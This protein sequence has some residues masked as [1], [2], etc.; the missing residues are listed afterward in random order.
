MNIVPAE[1]RSGAS[2]AA[3]SR[4]GLATRLWRRRRLF[5][6]VF[7]TVFGLSVAAL[8]VLPVRFAATGSVIVAEPE[9]GNANSSAAWAQ[10]SG[11]PADLESQ[12]L[13]VRSPR[14]LRLAMAEPG[15]VEAAQRECRASASG[16]A[17]FMGSASACDALAANSGALVDY[18]ESRVSVGNVGRSRVLTVTY[19]SPLP[20]VAQTIAN[21]VIT[22][23]MDDQRV[24]LAKSRE[25][26][27]SYIL[28]EIQQLDTTLRAEEARI[29]DFRR[30]RGLV[31]GST[32]PI[33]SE[34]LTS[35]SQQLA[36]AEAARADAR[37]RLREI[38]ADQERGSADS[39][40]VL[41]SRA[42]GDLKQQ[43]SVLSNQ[44]ANL[45]TTLGPNY[46]AMQSLRRERSQLQVRLRSEVASVAASSRQ[47]YDAAD[48]LVASL[49]AQLDSAKAE[50][51]SV[52]DAEATLADMRRGV[53][54]KRT[55]YADLFRRASELE[56]ERRIL[57]GST[58]IVS[59][60]ELPTRPFFP[61]RLPFL[62]AG[63]TLAT[64]LAGA[65]ALLR[66]RTDGTVRAAAAI[67]YATGTITV[68]HLPR[69]GSLRSAS[70][71]EL[72][73]G[74]RALVLNAALA[75]AAVDPK[76]QAALRALYA[77]LA[78]RPRQEALR[79]VLVTSASP[80][81]GKTF[82][83]IAL[84]CRI[85][86]SGKRVLV[87]EGDMCAPT[88]AD[89]LGLPAGPGLAEVLRGELAPGA[90]V[91]R[92]LVPNL[93]ALPAGPAVENSTELL[94]GP[95]TAK[96]FDLAKNYDLVLV[97]SPPFG[98]LLDAAVL[99]TGVDGVLVCA[100]W[101]RSQVD[102]TAATI[103]GIQAAGGLVVGAVLTMVRPQDGVL[104]G[105]RQV[106]AV[107]YQGPA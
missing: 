69:L 71:S 93:D 90:A 107:A 85:A 30:D 75:Q 23:F 40:A 17:R 7:V 22:A 88:F 103:T 53:E 95:H 77:Q 27:A 20:D 52:T 12:L 54:L 104:Y 44:I 65:A 4:T 6:G 80:D 49:K 70:R 61:R 45:E 31:R 68:A 14:I 58:R 5:L 72:V 9:P 50:V 92:T 55:Q 76:M 62:A 46:P 99:A 36:V 97:D 13:Q 98:L 105:E 21:A 47:T 100:R 89:A 24:N 48:T 42:I 3:A 102:A 74:R 82:T 28:Q 8:F 2:A 81:E 33:A 11:D 10:R 18:L 106:P 34:R 91:K 51:G 63:L 73:P 29:Q 1:G 43:Y 86:A 66:D 96:V 26:A 84:A 78:L 101:G 32:A 35:I 15:I 19:Q 59:L 38:S 83:T 56:T 79:T 94:L 16:L 57:T 37:A 67:G 87:V 39:P 41:S 60:A 64:L 25:S